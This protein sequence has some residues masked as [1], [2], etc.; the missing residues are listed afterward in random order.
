MGDD[1]GGRGVAVALLAAG[2]AVGLGA[3]LL[4]MRARRNHRSAKAEAIVALIKRRDRVGATDTPEGNAALI[5]LNCAA[6]PA[7][8]PERIASR[9]AID[10][11]AIAGGSA[12]VVAA[13]EATTN[14]RLI[15]LHG[16][17]FQ[18][19]LLKEH[20]PILGGLAART[21]VELTVPLYPLA[22]E[23]DW[24]PAFAMIDALYAEMVAA[25]GAQNVVIA[26]DSAGG[27]IALSLC[28]RWRDRG[29]PLPAR[30]VLISP[31]ADATVSD[32]AQTEIAKRDHILSID[33]LRDA[34]FSWAGARRTNDPVISPLFG[35][36]AGLPAML[37]LAG[38][39]DILVSDAR[40]LATS[41][42]ASGTDLRLSE[43]PG[44]F[45]VWLAAPIPEAERALDEAAAFILASTG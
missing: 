21:G 36:L 14:L 13:R 29:T 20:W 39:D 23:H 24:Q 41:A 18:L 45:H 6:G 3:A 7:A 34:G 38:T 40:R 16:G 2:A 37:V 19:D 11:R 4:S 27:G 32:P 12:Y 26:G 33:R 43:Y 15:Y 42:R 5:A 1:K 22:P 35:S 10:L 8:P 9:F 44:M 28:Q 17:A 25:V 31:W 30:L